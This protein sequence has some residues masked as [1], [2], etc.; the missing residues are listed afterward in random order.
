MRLVHGLGRHKQTRS[1][2]SPRSLLRREPLHEAEHFARI[3]KYVTRWQNPG[4]RYTPRSSHD[5]FGR[6]ARRY[7]SA[8]GVTNPTGAALRRASLRRR[9]S[10]QAEGPCSFP[11]PT[12]T[13]NHQVVLSDESGSLDTMP[14]NPL[15]RRL[16]RIER[17]LTR[18]EQHLDGME[19]SLDNIDLCVI[20]IPESG[21]TPHFR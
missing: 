12:L 9:Y 7:S 6:A 8:V 2:I 17:V 21:S 18:L 10:C 13:R 4:T 15:A 3:P 16:D 14:D 11:S 20:R 5:L 1:L 19:R